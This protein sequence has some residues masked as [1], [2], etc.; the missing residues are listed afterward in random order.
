MLESLLA[1]T[2]EFS[3]PVLATIFIGLFLAGLLLES[4]LLS[5]FSSI[6]RPLVAHARLPE[7]CASS[8]VL[9]M[10]STVAANGMIARFHEDELLESREVFLC[11]MI[12]SI[13]AYVRE[14]F[15]Y[16][17]PI[18][19]PSLGL[20]AGG[21]YASVFMVTALVKVSVVVLL[22]RIFFGQRSYNLQETIQPARP[23]LRAA[24][25]RALRG[26]TRLFLRISIVYLMMT[27]LIFTFK[28]AGLFQSSSLGA[29]A[30]KFDVPAETI[31][32][33]TT[34]V[35]SPIMGITML[36]PMIRGGGI[37]DIQAMIVLMLGS[38]F[39]LPVFALRS[40]VP[41]Y[42]ALFGARLGLSVVC[43]STGI[44]VLVRMAYLLVLLR[45]A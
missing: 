21:L 41:N 12:N 4:G 20:V 40:M 2:L 44:S 22:G 13:P 7:V 33:L 3:L 24:S 1:R 42:T 32:P 15:T 8:L 35:A 6:S 25:S 19:L 34:Y 9:S 5:S 37:T 26:Q 16:Q 29:L 43:F 28:D 11:A 39:M 10:G 45:L 38:I 18:V 31:V 17:I 30:G 36:G 23:S 27:L 14:I